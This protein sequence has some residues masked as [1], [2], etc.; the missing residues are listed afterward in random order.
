MLL[1]RTSTDMFESWDNGVTLPPGKNESV[2]YRIQP[3]LYYLTQ[4][5]SKGGCGRGLTSGPQQLVEVI[6]GVDDVEVI[7]GKVGLIALGNGVVI[8]SI[9][10]PCK[11]CF[12]HQW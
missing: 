11:R 1:E 6:L 7:G 9:G 8:Q 4:P 3:T 2:L 5:P 10:D 12:P